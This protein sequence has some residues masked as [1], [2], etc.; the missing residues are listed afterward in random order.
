[1]ENFADASGL[2]DQNGEEAAGESF[3]ELTESGS[4]IGGNILGLLCF[5]GTVVL[6]SIGKEF[7]SR[8]I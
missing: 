5:L 6:L 1:V 7:L 8:H 2:D 3:N 4:G